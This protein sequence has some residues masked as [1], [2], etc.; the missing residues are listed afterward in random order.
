MTALMTGYSGFCEQAPE[1]CV[2]G[3]TAICF[4][5]GIKCV[6]PTDSSNDG[7]VDPGQNTA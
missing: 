4:A 6:F 2:N 3:V 5:E 7:F 1:I